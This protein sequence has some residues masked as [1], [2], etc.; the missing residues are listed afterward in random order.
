[1]PGLSVVA[2]MSRGT[3][4]NILLILDWSGSN[5]VWKVLFFAYGSLHI[6]GFCAVMRVG[7]VSAEKKKLKT[8]SLFIKHIT[9]QFFPDDLVYPDNRT[10]PSRSISRLSYSSCGSGSAGG[11][12]GSSIYLPGPDYSEEED[13]HSQLYPFY[14]SHPGA[15]SHTS[16]ESLNS[17]TAP[18]QVLL[19]SFSHY[20]NSSLYYIHLADALGLINPDLMFSFWLNL[21]LKLRNGMNTVNTEYKVPTSYIIPTTAKILGLISISF[22]EVHTTHMVFNGCL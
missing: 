12:R 19:I 18:P 1:M 5:V 9:I 7:F 16:Q 15:Y 14:Q 22:I 11:P 2:K 13:A 4:S 3:Q 21:T 10:I 17:A 6:F 8:N 20:M